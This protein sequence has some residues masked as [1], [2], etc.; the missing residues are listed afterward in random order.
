MNCL[1]TKKRRKY[2]SLLNICN[3]I[4]GRAALIL[5]FAEYGEDFDTQPQQNKNGSEGDSAKAVNLVIAK[6]IRISA[7]TARHQY[8]AQCHHNDAYDHP[9][10]VFP[11]K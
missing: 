1:V 10:V 6:H 2:A 11:G 8:K 3:I 5:W 9:F 4:A 7:F